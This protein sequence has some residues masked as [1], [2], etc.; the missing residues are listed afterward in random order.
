MSIRLFN[1]ITLQSTYSLAKVHEYYGPR[2]LSW[3]KNG[4]SCAYVGN[5]QLK[6]IARIVLNS[7]LAPNHL[8][9]GVLALPSTRNV[10]SFVKPTR[11]LTGKELDE[12]R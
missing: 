11:R 6:G 8:K 9:G 3:T 2:K 12:R 10:N 1:P 4:R 7:N 5:S